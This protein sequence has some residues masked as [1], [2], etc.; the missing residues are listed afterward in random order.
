MGFFEITLGRAKLMQQVDTKDYHPDTTAAYFFL[1]AQSRELFQF[2]E[3]EA[4][5]DVLPYVGHQGLG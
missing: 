1:N 4:G 3:V 5:E 2:F